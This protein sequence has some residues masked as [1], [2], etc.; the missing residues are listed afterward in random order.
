MGQRFSL[1]LPGV[2]NQS[3]AL[4]TLQL[5][6]SASLENLEQLLYLRIFWFWIMASYCQLSTFLNS[7]LCL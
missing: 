7:I 2:K 1:L 6:W 5:Y 3:S 4:C